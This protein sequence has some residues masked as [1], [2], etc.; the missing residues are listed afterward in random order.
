M[1]TGAC[2]AFTKGCGAGSQLMPLGAR[3]AGL[4]PV[5][6]GRLGANAAN[7]S[8]CSGI[9]GAAAGGRATAG[10]GA[11]GTAIMGGGGGSG[12]VGAGEAGAC[13]SAAGCAACDHVGCT[14]ASG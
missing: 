1:G 13:P 14:G 11:L 3:A 8:L 12:C 10:V 9:A 5:A 7:M 6:I 2:A 4:G